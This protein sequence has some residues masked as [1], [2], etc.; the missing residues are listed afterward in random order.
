MHVFLT[1]W[2]CLNISQFSK[3]VMCLLPPMSAFSEKRHFNRISVNFRFW[4]LLT[5]GSVLV[6]IYLHLL[7]KQ[8]KSKEVSIS[9]VT[10]HRIGKTS[11]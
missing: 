1:F 6:R 10:V 3:T 9:K 7:F 11:T 4:H 8:N 2:Q 5:F